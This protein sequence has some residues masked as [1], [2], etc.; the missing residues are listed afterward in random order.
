MVKL[1]D[2]LF[3]KNRV[4]HF[5]LI[6]FFSIFGKPAAN[7]KLRRMYTRSSLCNKGT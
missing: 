5:T 1:V 7:T 3:S 6:F 4:S 2:E